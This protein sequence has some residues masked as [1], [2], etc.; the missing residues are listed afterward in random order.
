MRGPY[1]CSSKQR[2]LI[3]AESAQAA[4]TEY[5]VGTKDWWE[6]G[7]EIAFNESA[8]QYG[9]VTV[10]QGDTL[11]VTSASYAGTTVNPGDYTTLFFYEADGN[12]TLSSGDLLVG[13]DRTGAKPSMNGALGGDPA[14]TGS[15]YVVVIY[16][17]DPYAGQHVNQDGDAVNN[18]EWQNYVSANAWYQ[19]QPF[20]VVEA[21]KSLEGA[22]A[23]EVKNDP[24][25]LN[26]ETLKYNAT[27]IN[28]AFK[29]N[30]EKLVEGEDYRIAWIS[31][32][33][34]SNNVQAF[35]WSPS[36]ENGSYSV[37]N[38]GDYTAKLYGM[39]AY[40][41]TEADVTVH[42]APINLS[43][44][45]IT[46]DMA[47]NSTG[48]A[49]GAD[50][51]SWENATAFEV[52]VNGESA[53]DDVI[54]RIGF[55]AIHF[56]NWNGAQA[57]GGWT[58]ASPYT[59]LGE[60]EFLV[61]DPNTGSG[62]RNVIG[63]SQTVSLTIVDE[64]ATLTYDG[65]DFDTYFTDR[66]YNNAQ[67]TSFNPNLIKATLADGTVVDHEITVTRDGEDVTGGDYTQPGRYTLTVDV[68]VATQFAYGA[69]VTTTFTVIAK[70]I[71]YVDYYLSL[72][73]KAFTGTTE[74]DGEAVVPTV[75][76]KEGSDTLV[77]GEDYVVS[78]RDAEGNDVESMVNPGEYEIVISFP[79]SDREDDPI[80]VDLT[81]TKATIESAEA[82]ADYFALPEDGSAAV[83][84]F[85]G[86]NNVDFDKGVKFDL[87]AEDIDVAYY[88]AEFDEGTDANSTEDDDWIIPADAER[89]AAEDLTEAGDYMAVITLKSTCETL[90]GADIQAHFQLSD[91]VAYADVDANAWYADEVY[92]AKEF[93]YMTGIP[94]T[95]L[96]LPA[97]DISRAQTAQVL[98]N[99]AGGPLAGT[100]TSAGWFPTEFSDVEAWAWYAEP[101]L[102]AS[103][104]GVV[105]GYGETGTFGP[106]DDVTREQAATMLYR[107]M[108]AQGK[109]V[110]GAADLSGYAD[111]ASVSDWAAEAM[112]W[113][114]DAEVFGVGT[115]Q[116]RP[117]ENLSRAEMA[118]ISVR[119]Q[120][121][122]AIEA[123]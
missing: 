123:L 117:Q 89:I 71:G 115:D 29:A 110:S 23:Y 122:G 108:K 58:D 17:E 28:F 41:G 93:G 30:G 84:T 13:N 60:W 72:D 37:I 27:T 54:N 73:G 4:D 120:P 12:S 112:A 18:I 53:S 3:P 121:D 63:D 113:A 101:I 98:Y 64:L 34:L 14:E 81:I 32:T 10:E 9:R 11:Y 51:K 78:Y 79:G 100:G 46:I 96:F 20:S 39:G 57:T 43:E 62:Y 44:D 16:G 26:D 94:G 86:S 48:V 40:E 107:Y 75:S 24:S 90:M 49:I 104:A 87:S 65:T 80:V 77:A 83:P 50:G 118:A 6:N 7:V 91:V 55:N 76:V 61:F 52:K 33:D 19:S 85:T 1:I 35:T 74:Y 36:G 97:G 8:D 69:H 66:V 114:V 95:N 105:T 119:V 92:Q 106:N 31:T 59:D 99:M 88:P 111:S 5:Q 38:A 102:W 2:L 42:V 56:T 103:Q 82:T 70:H 109:D 68:P 45:V 25:N 21:Q 67:G 47:D 15:Y 116:L 22:V